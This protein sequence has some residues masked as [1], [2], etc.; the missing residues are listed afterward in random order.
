[1]KKPLLIAALIGATALSAPAFARPMT[2]TD[3]ATMKRLSGA[4]ASPDG[5]M[6]AYQVRETDLDANK[7]RTDLYLIKL[8]TPNEIGRAS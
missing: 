2:E 5:T 7:G 3:L 4:A 1:M 6:I 8:G